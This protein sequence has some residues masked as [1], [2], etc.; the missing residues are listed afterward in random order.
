MH[1]YTYNTHQTRQSLLEEEFSLPLQHCGGIVGHPYFN[2][3]ERKQR[4]FFVWRYE[5]NIRYRNAKT[6]LA[7]VSIALQVHARPIS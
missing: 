4:V 7:I 6:S 1:W 2:I 3:H 5:A